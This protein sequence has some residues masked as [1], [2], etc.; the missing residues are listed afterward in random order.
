M[1]KLKKDMRAFLDG[2]FFLALAVV[3]EGLILYT[4]FS[5]KPA[6]LLLFSQ[7][8][9]VAIGLY[10]MGNVAISQHQITVLPEGIS[11]ESLFKQSFLAWEEIDEIGFVDV[12]WRKPKTQYVYF[13][14]KCLPSRCRERLSASFFSILVSGVF[15]ALAPELLPE[16]LEPFSAYRKLYEQCYSDGTTVHYFQDRTF[17]NMRASFW[18]SSTCVELDIGIQFL[19]T[20]I[21]LLG[22]NDLLRLKSLLIAIFYLVLFLYL[23]LFVRENLKGRG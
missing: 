4:V 18:I 3:L 16:E 9:I 6:F 1:M 14:T 12:E 15:A 17:Q 2:L 10:G 7:L 22:V 13:S 21:V 8:S 23:I 20:G 11:V 19:L 5:G